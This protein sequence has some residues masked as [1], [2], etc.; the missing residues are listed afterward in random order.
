MVAYAFNLS[1]LEA[2]AWGITVSF[3]LVYRVSSQSGRA[4]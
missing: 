2:E 3:K 4:T 1:T